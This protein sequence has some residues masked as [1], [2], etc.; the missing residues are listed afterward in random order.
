MK[1]I[2]CQK[3]FFDFTHLRFGCFRLSLI[4]FYTNQL[5]HS[6]LKLL[7]LLVNLPWVDVMYWFGFF[8]VC[9]YFLSVGQVGRFMVSHLMFSE[10]FDG[11]DLNLLFSGFLIFV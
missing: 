2:Y 9:D 11:N 5:R 1:N 6:Q 7:K 4:L 10:T 3:L 8:Y